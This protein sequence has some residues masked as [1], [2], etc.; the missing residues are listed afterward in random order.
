MDRAVATSPLVCG[1]VHRG[2]TTYHSSRRRSSN[3]VCT[4]SC[5]APH[6]RESP[7]TAGWR[8]LSLVAMVALG[9]SITI[10]CIWNRWTSQ[11]Q[12]WEYAV[13]GPVW[14]F[15][16][17]DQAAWPHLV[18]SGTTL[19]LT[20]VQL[21]P[22]G[23]LGRRIAL[24]ASSSPIIIMVNSGDEGDDSDGA[25]GTPG[26]NRGMAPGGREGRA[27]APGRRQDA[28]QAPRARFS[29]STQTQGPPVPQRCFVRS[30]EE[31]AQPAN[32]SPRPIVVGGAR[33]SN[34]C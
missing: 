30:R 25:L 19:P 21:W 8:R 1:I 31:T 4:S 16:L 13:P 24:D 11:R 9:A 27:R 12:A 34:S 18:A 17:P 7:G 14:E 29:P 10:V 20:S 2:S 33:S 26:T 32:A 23:A 6:G 28:A 3:A 22:A 5:G 15:E